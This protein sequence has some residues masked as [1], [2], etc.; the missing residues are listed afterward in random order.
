MI[1]P[2]NIPQDI[3]E[4]TIKIHSP[5]RFKHLNPPLNKDVWVI[6]REAGNVSAGFD[7]TEKALSYL[8]SHPTL[9]ED[10]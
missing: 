2:K 3:G 1:N 5:G 4:V 7:T 8:E 10:K 6:L 9:K